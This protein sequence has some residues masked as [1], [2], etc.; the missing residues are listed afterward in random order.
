MALGSVLGAGCEKTI[1]RSHESHYCSSTADDEPYYECAKGSDLICITT[2]TMTYGSKE[3]APPKT[4]DIWVCRLACTPGNKDECRADEVCCP[5]MIYGN[6]YGKSHACVM[7]G[8]CPALAVPNKDAGGGDARSDAKLD[9]GLS[10][11]SGA[12][13]GGSDGGADGPAADAPMDLPPG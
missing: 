5:G 13:A 3:G 6:N 2:Y 10:D 11:G 7:P 8:L 4:L 1:Y 9:S 12:D